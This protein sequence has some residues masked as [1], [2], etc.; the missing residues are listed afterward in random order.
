MI[1]TPTIEKRI[2]EAVFVREVC[3][4]AYSTSTGVATPAVKRR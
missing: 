1:E 3:G 2:A 4:G